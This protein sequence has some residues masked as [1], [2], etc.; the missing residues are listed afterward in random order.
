[1]TDTNPEK[2]AAIARERRRLTRLFSAIDPKRKA[3]VRG[4]IERCAF[5]AVSLAE[6]EADLNTY[7]FVEL[8]QQGTAPAYERKRPIADQYNT[9]S[10]NYHKAIKQ[11]TDLLPKDDPAPKDDGFDAFVGGRR[12]L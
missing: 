3:A 1:M 5:M 4:L 8:F 11:L 9:M 2:E 12:E 10:A 6:I 7:G